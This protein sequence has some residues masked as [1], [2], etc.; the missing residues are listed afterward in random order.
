MIK[1]LFAIVGILCA[2]PASAITPDLVVQNRVMS[3]AISFSGDGKLLAAVGSWSMS[4]VAQIWDISTG[5]LFREFATKGSQLN[6]VAFSI[7]G[8]DLATCSE[9]GGAELWG[10][11]NGLRRLTLSHRDCRAMAFSPNGQFIAITTH[12]DDVKGYKNY[13]TLLSVAD[14]QVIR[15]IEM[16]HPMS[17]AFSADSSILV[18]GSFDHVVR[19]WDVAT[20]GIRLELKGHLGSV[21]KVSISEKNQLIASADDDS[22]RVWS[23]TSGKTLWSD[24]VKT[25]GIS[26][27][28][29]GNT[30][31]LNIN[32]GSRGVERRLVNGLTG[33]LEKVI[34]GSELLPDTATFSRGG[35]LLAIS[36]LPHGGRSMEGG[37]EIWNV[38]TGQLLREIKSSVTMSSHVTFSPN[39]TTIAV[40][41]ENGIHLWDLKTLLPLR[42]SNPDRTNC[43]SQQGLTFTKSG[44]SILA[45]TRCDRLDL[46]PLNSEGRREF[47]PTTGAVVGPHVLS[48]DGAFVIASLTSCLI[49]D[50]NCMQGIQSWNVKTGALQWFYPFTY[51]YGLHDLSISSDGEQ[52][53]VAS[54]VVQFLDSLS[55]KL[56]KQKSINYHG[57]VFIQAEPYSLAFAKNGRVAIGSGFGHVI[58]LENYQ[59]D[60]GKYLAYEPLGEVNTTHSFVQVLKYSPNDRLLLAG[61]SDGILL[62]LQ[63]SNKTEVRAHAGAI[64]SISFSPDGRLVATVGNDAVIRIWDAESK[65]VLVSL[66]QVAEND[67]I[68]ATPSGMY[69][70]TPGAFSEVAFRVGERVYPFEQFDMQLNRPD[71]VL[72]SIGLGS[73]ETVNAYRRARIKRLQRLGVDENIIAFDSHV[74][75]LALLTKKIGISTRERVLKIRVRAEDALTALDHLNVLV[76]D[77]PIGGLRGIP[78]AK[79]T[80]SVEIDV[81][82]ELSAGR[83]SVRISVVNAKQSESL[84]EY[85]EIYN[86][87]PIVNPTTYVLA[88]G[89]SKYFN[90]DYN[91]EYAAKDALDIASLFEEIGGKQNTKVLRIMDK[92]ATRENI[93]AAKS[94]LLK[95][96]VNDTVIVFVAGHGL[97]DNKF[98]YYFATTD[99]DANS[100][101][102]RGLPFSG[103]EELLD[104][105]ASRNKL[106]LVDSCN[107]GEFD[108][109]RTIFD[110]GTKV[111][112]GVVRTRTIRALRP[113]R[114]MVNSDFNNQIL[115]DQFA[116]LRR[117]SG[118]SIISATGGAE[119]AFES[120]RWRNGVFTYSLL[121]GLKS[122]ASDSNYDGKITVSELREYVLNAVQRLTQGGQKPTSRRASREFDFEISSNNLLLISD[123]AATWDNPLICADSPDI[124]KCEC[125]MRGAKKY[126]KSLQSLFTTM[127]EVNYATRHGLPMPSE[128][129]KLLAVFHEC[130][131]DRLGIDQSAGVLDATIEIDIHKIKC[132][133]GM[134]LIN[135]DKRNKSLRPFCI[136][137]TELSVMNFEQ[138]VKAGTCSAKFVMCDP[139]ANYAVLGKE[140]HP[141]N[142][143]GWNDA[144][145]Y[146]K[147]VGKRL[148]TSPEWSWASVGGVSTNKFPWGSA[149]PQSDICW[150]RAE[151]SQASWLGTCVVGSSKTDITQQGVRDMAA[152]VG[153]WTSTAG[154]DVGTKIAIGGGWADNDSSILMST[155]P[156][157]ASRRYGVLGFRC[158]KD[159]LEAR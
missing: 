33:K 139:A 103:L 39:G 26:F 8:R 44:D 110:D 128:Y 121:Y 137:Q 37:I 133:Q 142:C 10:V 120:D 28:P 5:K 14:G 144:E 31:Y 22:V 108:A 87:A 83:N 62:F 59:D 30:L 159:V 12:S 43:E 138:C 23:I 58:E 72:S 84:S 93:L 41:G 79:K 114:P 156:F 4:G 119:F 102:K 123:Q 124:A 57:N 82:I 86:A 152:N 17:I 40:A 50:K 48:P 77:V 112:S 125:H 35:D 15:S 158:A 131:N 154:D 73:T 71:Q 18:S 117:G 74:P 116:D 3:R 13:V 25:K 98:E 101:E 132:P 140:T 76:N 91:L 94:F 49:R 60:V 135:S 129:E 52:I 38:P 95:A 127:H 46:L 19:I 146:C 1:T 53:A 11:K 80:G 34:N 42:L 148:P 150:R 155:Q 6:D 54:K 157:D 99:I 69:S 89:I 113:I 66:I 65:R 7:D 2:F 68:F 20:G 81:P 118:A 109:Q 107:S 115:I 147:W 24:A 64:T 55:G 61:R 143:V 141:M 104:G 92:E 75:T 151:G 145:S 105:L 78:L 56:L 136:D 27:E 29:G 85:F 47:M 51:Q 45:S 106:L 130:K 126:F 100:P 36:G 90:S 9:D 21:G 122:G 96:N 67:F 16:P 63:G 153:E 70:A 88:I 111:D 32:R 149:P 97:L 134:A